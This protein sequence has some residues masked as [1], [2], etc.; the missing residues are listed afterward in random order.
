MQI[1]LESQVL[2]ELGTYRTSTYGFIIR[3]GGEGVVVSQQVK[4]QPADSGMC[5]TCYVLP[6]GLSG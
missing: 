6:R 5:L 4:T 3:G 2:T 1:R